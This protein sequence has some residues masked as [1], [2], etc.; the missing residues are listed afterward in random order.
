MVVSEDGYIRPEQRETLTAEED[1][2]IADVCPGLGLKQEPGARQDHALWGPLISVRTGYA[3]DPALRYHSSS[4]GVLSAILVYLVETGTVDF[5]LQIAAATDQPLGNGTVLSRD[6]EA[7]FAAAG[8]RY[9]PSSPLAE[10]EEH[11]AR[12]KCFAFVGKPCDVAALRR[13]AEHDPRID[14]CVPYMLSFFCAGIPSLRGAAEIVQTLGLAPEE[15]TA[16]RYRGDGW[17]GFATATLKDGSEKSMT[18][19]DS[20]GGILTKHVQ[21]RC[22]ICPDGT[23]GFADIACADAWHCDADGYPLFEET[24]GLSLVVTRTERGEKLLAEALARGYVAA[25]PL[26]VTDIAAMQPG[27]VRRK[28]SVLSR[29]LALRALRQ[30]SPCYDGFHLWPVARQAGIRQHLRDFLATC[31]RIVRRDLL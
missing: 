20:W 27:Q 2:K 11:L 22:R 17:P 3:T 28:Q 12:G 4:G 6:G 7:I 14:A 15:V 24:E 19:R 29:L 31:A 21:F 25:K 16:F 26:P 8:S 30:P 23:G 9:A 13:M 1:G 5:V 18:Y 10:L